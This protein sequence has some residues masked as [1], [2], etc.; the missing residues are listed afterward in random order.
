MWHRGNVM[1]QCEE[2]SCSPLLAWNFSTKLIWVHWHTDFDIWTFDWESTRS[3]EPEV[4][5]GSGWLEKLISRLDICFARQHMQEG[6]MT[7]RIRT[8]P[9]SKKKLPKNGETFSSKCQLFFRRNHWLRENSWTIHDHGPLP[10][11]QSP[12][13]M[14]WT[15]A[16]W[17]TEFATAQIVRMKTCLRA[18]PVCQVRARALLCCRSWR[19]AVFEPIRA[20]LM[21][22]NEI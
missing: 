7:I 10:I 2:W 17:M 16:S 6:N 14:A 15:D 19:L 21:R 5:F 12:D 22:S 11:L 3:A 9:V 4:I 1:W 20:Y 8:A 13:A 18:R